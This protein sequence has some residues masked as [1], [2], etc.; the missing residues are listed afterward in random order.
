MIVDCEKFDVNIMNLHRSMNISTDFLKYNIR[1]VIL[2]VIFFL[3]CIQLIQ[4]SLELLHVRCENE[5]RTGRCKVTSYSETGKLINL[6]IC[7][8]K[9]TSQ[10]IWIIPINF[11]T[12]IAERLNKHFWASVAFF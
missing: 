1:S 5:M 10:F 4:F 8:M 7:Y 3:W 11:I 9:R 2:L 12:N 6:T